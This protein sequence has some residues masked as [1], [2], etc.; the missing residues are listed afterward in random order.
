MIKSLPAPGD[1]HRGSALVG[2]PLAD[3][4][5]RHANQ[6]YRLLTDMVHPPPLV[7]VGVPSF[8]TSAALP[9]RNLGFLAVPTFTTGSEAYSLLVLTMLSIRSGGKKNLMPQSVM[10]D[11]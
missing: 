9:R 6:A 8:A 7:V 11:I 2:R 3:M 5:K 4:I 1:V 10:R